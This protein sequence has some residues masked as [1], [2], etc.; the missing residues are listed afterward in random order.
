MRSFTPL[1][2]LLVA[3]PLSAQQADTTRVYD[4]HEVEVAPRPRNTPEF[5]EAL[6]RS[7]PPHLRAAGVGGTVQVG[8]VVGADGGPGEV[9]VLSTPDTGLDGPSVQAVA[10]LRFDPAQV[11]GR[12]VPVRV[13]LP[14]TWRVEAAPEPARQDAAE[15]APDTAWAYEL[16]EVDVLPRLRN[17]QAVQRALVAGYPAPLRQEGREGEVLVRFRIAP[18]GTTGHFSVVRATHPGFI[19]PSFAAFRIALFTPARVDGRPVPVWVTQPIAWTVD[20]SPPRP[21][22]PDP[23]DPA[24]GGRPFEGPRDRTRRP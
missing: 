9:R 1:L 7:Y 11:Q 12:A 22:F 2:A 21:P 18:D 19:E 3:M 24:F 23:R 20:M 8:F 13:E 5:I 4:L 16:E 6:N 14:I 10:L 15:A 17:A